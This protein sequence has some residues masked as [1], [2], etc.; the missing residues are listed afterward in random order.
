MTWHSS[1]PIGDRVQPERRSAASS[2]VTLFSGHTSRVL[3]GE[4][5]MTLVR[6]R[7][8]VAQR[9]EVGQQRIDVLVVVPGPVAVRDRL[10]AAPGPRCL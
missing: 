7:S 8:S 3:V 10:A 2:G 5:R 1:T 9:A 6:R 4:P